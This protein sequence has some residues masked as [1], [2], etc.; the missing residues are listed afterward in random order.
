[1]FVGVVVFVVRVSLF[2]FFFEKGSLPQTSM[3]VHK[4]PFQ[5]ES[6]F[7]TGVLALPC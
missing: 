5:E 7:S 4:P 6:N 2:F 1:M 3:E